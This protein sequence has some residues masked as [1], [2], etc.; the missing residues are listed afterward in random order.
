MSTAPVLPAIEAEHVSASYRVRVGQSSFNSSVRE[1]LRLDE[2]PQ[3]IVPALHD[4]SFTVPKGTV[5]AVVGRNGA[6][7]S[8]LLRTIAGILAPT[9]GRITVRGRITSLLSMGLG[10]NQEMTGR[11]NISLGGLA[12]GL[13]EARLAVLA[14]SIADFAQLG[15]Y[16]DFPVK[17]YS[18]G[19]KSRLAFAV[20][21]HLDPEVLLID[22]ALA[23]G[24]S[25]FK[26]RTALRMYELCNSG[27]TI[28]LV[29]HGLSTV[30]MMA[31]SALWLHQGKVVEFGDPD[32]VVASYMRYCRIEAL[33][34]LDDE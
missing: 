21:A 5:L 30:K 8:T 2:A 16:I 12:A 34:G 32:E 26:E 15:E 19:M 31:T 29:T 13:S 3:R 24:D 9:E 28:V 27:R 10:F 22:E 33:E 14:D 18:S 1:L 11:E 20:A 17:G 25:K 4:V 7:K 6:G 23:G